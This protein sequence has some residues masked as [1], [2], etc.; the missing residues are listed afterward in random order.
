MFRSMKTTVKKMDFDKV[1]ALPRYEH[2]A[3]RKPNIFWRTLIRLLTIVGMAGTK[4]KYEKERM[5]LLGKDEPCLILMN[6]TCFQDM[7]VAHKI[8]FPRV[9]NI[10]CSN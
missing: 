4:F 1:M 5:E 9:F 10:V 7:E 3:P 2:K 8:L 6:H